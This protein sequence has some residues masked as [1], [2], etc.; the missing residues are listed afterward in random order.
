[1]CAVATH[2]VCGGVAAAFRLVRGSG[3][4]RAV[5][6]SQL[7]SIHKEVHALSHASQPKVRYIETNFGLER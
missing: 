2:P 7:A 3:E 4:T 5:G 6:G 1:M